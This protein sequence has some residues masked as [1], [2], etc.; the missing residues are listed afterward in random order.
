[1]EKEGI[2]MFFTDAKD[3]LIPT[4]LSLDSLWRFKGLL[5]HTT[6][7]LNSLKSRKLQRGNNLVMHLIED[8]QVLSSKLYTILTDLLLATD[9]LDDA[10]K[11]TRLHRLVNKLSRE[12]E[13]IESLTTS[14]VQNDNYYAKDQPDEFSW[15][16]NVIRL[17]ANDLDVDPSHLLVLFSLYQTIGLRSFAYTGEFHTLDLPV[18]ILN[19]PWEWSVV[20]HE[21]AGLKVKEIKRRFPNIMKETLELVHGQVTNK[22]DWTE[23]YLE[24]L[25]EDAGSILVFGKELID[26][27]ESVLIR[28]YDQA[29]TLDS[30]HPDIKVR[31]NIAHLL[32]GQESPDATPDQKAVAKV[33]N[34]QLS[35]YLPSQKGSFDNGDPHRIILDAIVAYKMSAAD[36]GAIFENVRSLLSNTTINVPSLERSKQQKEFPSIVLPREPNHEYLELEGAPIKLFNKFTTG[37]NKINGILNLT[38]SESDYMSPSDHS[39]DAAHPDKSVTIRFSTSHGDHKWSHKKN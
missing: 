38:L 20:W 4:T 36:G 30:R 18:T 15:F 9:K 26:I 23:D 31:V 24:E 32:L 35:G 5:E 3:K 21:I 25:F 16:D 2:T 39:D 29:G 1:M 6:R 14:V 19:T 10:Q 28:T 27:F 12:L 33:I 8:Y 22:S 7:L 37:E 11:S 13:Y 34:D 17:A